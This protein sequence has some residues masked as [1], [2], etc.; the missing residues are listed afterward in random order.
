[1]FIILIQDNTTIENVSK[2]PKLKIPHPESQIAKYFRKKK[3]K[4]ITN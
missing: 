2:C 4:I 1:M 3:K